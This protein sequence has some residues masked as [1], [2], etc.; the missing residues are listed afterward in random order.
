MRF[1]LNTVVATLA[2]YNYCDMIK[3][4]LL[5]DGEMM[6]RDTHS[7]IVKSLHLRYAEKKIL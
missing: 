4:S 2:F 1:L 6:K 5:E 3:I 7:S